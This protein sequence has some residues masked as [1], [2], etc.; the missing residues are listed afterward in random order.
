MTWIALVMGCVV[1]WGC[2][3]VLCGVVCCCENGDGKPVRGLTC[4]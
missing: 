4:V 2:C 1:L 3:V